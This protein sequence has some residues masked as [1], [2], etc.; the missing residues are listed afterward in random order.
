MKYL[1]ITQYVYI[2]L[3]AVLFYMTFEKWSAD[4]DEKWL[5][6]AL[7]VMCVA[8]FVVRYRFIKRLKSRQK[9]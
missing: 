1:A 6:L 4:T 5:L 3:A 2:V 7:G 9:E 8:L